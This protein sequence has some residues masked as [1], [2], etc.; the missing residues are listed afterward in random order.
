MIRDLTVSIVNYNSGEYLTRCLESI[1]LVGDEAKIK[2]TVIDNNS[3]DKSLETARGLFPKVEFI[4]N[5]DN[6][7]FGKAHNQ[8]L[9][10]LDTEY[11]LLL[12]PDCILEKGVIKKLLEYIEKNPET[13]AITCKIILP[14]GT[15]DLTAHRGLPTPW[16]SLLYFFGDNSKY[17]LT[18]RDLKSPHEVDSISGAFFLTKKEVLEKSG[19]FDE[20]FFLYGEDIDLSVRIHDAGFKVIYYPDV[21]ITHYKGVSSG[22]K[23]HSQDITRADSKT[24]LLAVNAFYEAM[25]IFYDKHFKRKY[26]FLINWLVYLGIYLRWGLAL[27]KK[28]V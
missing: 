10:N 7:G 20:K 26:F 22:L 16:A 13:G 5:K 4:D 24:K 21:S 17:H 15:V 1:K 27:L 11:V 3:T 19:F 23:K 25:F 18:N 28:T 14:D 9:K 2:T 6:I 8:V 12:N